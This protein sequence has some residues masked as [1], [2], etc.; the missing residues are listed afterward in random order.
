MNQDKT[1]RS[2]SKVNDVFSPYY[3]LILTAA[4]FALLQIVIAGYSVGVGNQTIQIP[5]VQRF[6]DGG[7]YAKDVTLNNTIDRY[8]SYF[9]RLLAF[10]CRLVDYKIVYAFFHLLSGFLLALAILQASLVL[11]SS[12]GPGLI[13][14]I[15]LLA[16]HH[17]ALAGAELYVAGFTHTWFSFAVAVWS[18]V[19]L[20]QKRFTWSLITVGLLFNIHALM[21]AYAAFFLLVMYVSS[22]QFKDWRRFMVSGLLAVV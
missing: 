9:Y 19:F 15:I 2:L 6:A 4:A 5:F 13:C 10:F 14:L 11:W 8:P 17:R 21:A 7:L 18:F 1:I 3:V 12:L 16:G 22:W 20:W